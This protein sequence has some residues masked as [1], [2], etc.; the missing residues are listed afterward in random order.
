MQTQTQTQT[1]TGAGTD[2]NSHTGAGTDTRTKRDTHRKNHT[3]RR[4]VRR[5]SEGPSPPKKRGAKERHPAFSSGNREAP[6]MAL[7]GK[8]CVINRFGQ[9]G[10]IWPVFFVAV[11][12]KFNDPVVDVEIT[13]TI[14]SNIGIS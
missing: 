6:K 5:K 7:L 11:F 14:S 2:T 1:H 8:R 3:H 10:T 4:R 9:F 13:N 12:S